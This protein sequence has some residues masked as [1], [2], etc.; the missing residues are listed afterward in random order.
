MDVLGRLSVTSRTL[1]QGGS[2]GSAGQWILCTPNWI[3]HRM[4]NGQTLFSNG[5]CT[6]HLMGMYAFEVPRMYRDRQERGKQ[7]MCIDLVYSDQGQLWQSGVQIWLDMWRWVDYRGRGTALERDG[8]RCN[9]GISWHNTGDTPSA[10]PLPSQP[11]DRQQ[12]PSRWK[13][14]PAAGLPFVKTH[15]LMTN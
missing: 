2:R 12:Q 4:Q 5:I 3:F 7:T 6:L 11:T 9:G 15:P 13:L 14:A 10:L 1:G 8:V